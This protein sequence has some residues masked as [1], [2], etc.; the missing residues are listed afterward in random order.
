M[1][2]WVSNI[3]MTCCAQTFPLTRVPVEFTEIDQP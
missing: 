3:L 1:K 2:S